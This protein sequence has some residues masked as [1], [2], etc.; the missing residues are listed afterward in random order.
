MATLENSYLYTDDCSWA[1]MG[2]RR[3]KISTP[4]TAGSAGWNT[5]ALA[6]ATPVW[7]LW[8]LNS[9]LCHHYL[10]QPP[11]VPL[12][13]VS[14]DKHNH[15]VSLLQQPWQQPQHSSNNILCHSTTHSFLAVSLNHWTAFF[16]FSLIPYT[17]Y[18]MHYIVTCTW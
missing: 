15:F 1:V 10:V 12:E 4:I 14:H 5:L 11:I 18:Y 9:S 13:G 16:K 3:L 6:N 2:T 17:V 8:L 7:L